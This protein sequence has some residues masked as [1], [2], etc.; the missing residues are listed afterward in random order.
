MSSSFN[1]FIFS[2]SF[3]TIVVAR[4]DQGDPRRAIGEAFQKTF[5]FNQV[6]CKEEQEE[7]EA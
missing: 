5:D 3:L 2:V 4:G 6:G 7:K 1:A